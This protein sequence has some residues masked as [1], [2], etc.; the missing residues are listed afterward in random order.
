[1][2]IMMLL[3]KLEEDGSACLYTSACS[4][5]DKEEEAG[6][7]G[8]TPACRRPIDAHFF[9]DLVKGAAQTSSQITL[10]ED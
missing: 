4:G 9:S 2:V 8:V 1:M 10:Y 3:G 7:C 6:R 5:G